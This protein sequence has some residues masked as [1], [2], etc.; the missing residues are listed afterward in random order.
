MKPINIPLFALAVAACLPLVAQQPPQSP[1]PQTGST[2]QV[3]SPQ[4]A[5]PEPGSSQGSSSAAEPVPSTSKSP[6]VSNP[7]L[8]PV[9]GELVTRLDTKE[10]KTGD[11]VVI[12]TTE[13]ATTATGVEIPKG[14][15]IT[16]H[17]TDVEAKGKSGDNSRLTIQLDQAEIKGGQ[18][19]LIRSVIQSVAPA[20][21]GSGSVDANGGPPASSPSASSSGSPASGT[22]SPGAASTASNGASNPNVPS[23]AAD[24]PPPGTVVAQKGN[25]AIRTT[26]IPGVLLVGNVTGQPFANAAGALLGARQDVHLDDG[27]MMVVSIMAAPPV[28]NAR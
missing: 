10:A 4:Q 14:S 12:R 17:I 9:T 26:S 3:T 8:R 28:A 6:E 18:N 22:T 2:P 7:Q 16:G 1:Q 15:K 20:G 19:L 27:T 25:I 11:S 24:L 13:Q 21:S 23:Q 5:S